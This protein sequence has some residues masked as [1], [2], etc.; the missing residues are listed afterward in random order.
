MQT[1]E[2]YWK[3]SP[4]IKLYGKIWLPESPVRAMIIM[5]HGI[6][7]HCG[8][9]EHLAEKYAD[10]FVGFLAFDLR[11]HGRSPGKRGHTTLKDI[12][13][14]LRTVIRNV[15]KK[16]PK[17]PVILYGHSMGG[18][19]VL[20]YA[21]DKKVKVQGIIASS[22]WLKLEHP[23]AVFLIKLAKAVSRILPSLTVQTG[24][25]SDQ[26]AKGETATK[27]TKTDPLMHKKISLKLFADL[28]ENGEKILCSKHKLN[29][30]LLLMHGKDDRLTSY[31]A[32][33]LFAQN[34][35][36]FTDF[37]AWKNMNHDLHNDQGNEAVFQ[38][39][40]KWILRLVKNNGTIQNNSKMY[41][42][43]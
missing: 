25:T 24:V 18:H 1:E 32:S 40:L 3:I 30:P 41:R 38:Y 22:P 28:W 37:K 21:L 9:Y 20:S 31:Q 4:R 39:T 2:C 35:G 34:A 19:A 15:R 36:K 5:V 12:K 8:C 33:K 43:A 14:D 13:N 26:L 17:V 6:G 7:E 29:I 27:S 23:P 16:F 42:V 11:G 10:Q